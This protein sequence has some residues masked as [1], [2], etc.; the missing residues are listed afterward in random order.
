MTEFSFFGWTIPLIYGPSSGSACWTCHSGRSE[1]ICDR[2][3]HISRTLALGVTF[4]I[5]GRMR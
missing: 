5:P 2:C 1:R 3:R 4:I